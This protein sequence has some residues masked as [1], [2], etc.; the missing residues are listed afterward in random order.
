MRDLRRGVWF[1]VATLK[2]DA[3][4]YAHLLLH[5]QGVLAGFVTCTAH[6]A[7]LSGRERETGII[8]HKVTK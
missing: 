1:E 6:T 8:L 3:V 5:L 7:Q 4:S 2:R